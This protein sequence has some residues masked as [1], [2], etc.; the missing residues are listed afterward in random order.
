VEASK[1]ALNELENREA[2]KA[3]HLAEEKKQAEENA[4]VIETKTLSIKAKA[5]ASG[6]LFGAVT[7]KEIAEELKAQT[8]IAVDKRKIITPEIKAYGEYTC[9]V[10][11]N[12]GITAK[13]MVQI[14]E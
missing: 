12:Q 13:L 8:G 5:G 9:E 7:A 6:R 3:H 10:K 11:L 14:G 4:K 2:A 1:N